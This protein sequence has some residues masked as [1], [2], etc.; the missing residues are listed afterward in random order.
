MELER[1]ALIY[2]RKF[3]DALGLEERG[4]ACLSLVLFDTAVNCGGIRAVR[5]LQE[6]LGVVV[7]GQCGPK[8]QAA[9]DS[10]EPEEWRLARHV[11]ERRRDHY[12]DLAKKTEW[13]LK[14][15]RGWLNR[16]FDLACEAA[17]LH[18]REGGSAIQKQALQECAEALRQSV[19]AGRR[20]DAVLTGVGGVRV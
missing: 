10:R 15:I 7:D 3:W 19:H 20:A 11:L 18:G 8:T 9:W 16:T 6:A 13:G 14:Y 1:A 12:W 2:R 17:E 5:W 4:G